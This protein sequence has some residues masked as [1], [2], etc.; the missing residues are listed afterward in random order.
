MAGALLVAGSAAGVPRYAE[1]VFFAD[2]PAEAA[3][4]YVVFKLM[5]WPD[6]KVL[7]N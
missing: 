7:L 2:D 1:L 5:G 3:V 6:I 4:N